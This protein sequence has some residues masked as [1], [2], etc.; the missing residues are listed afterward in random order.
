MKT[1]VEVKVINH[2]KQVQDIYPSAD[3]QFCIGVMIFL[4]GE[5]EPD[6]DEPNMMRQGYW[7]SKN[8]KLNIKYKVE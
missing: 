2:W 4:R 8:D 7:I 1:A 6:Y 5:K 3:L